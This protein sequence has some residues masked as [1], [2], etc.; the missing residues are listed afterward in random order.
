MPC[1]PMKAAS[2][3]RVNGM[4]RFP[5][6]CFTGRGR[7]VRYRWPRVIGRPVVT[8][9]DGSIVVT[10]TPY[11]IRIVRPEIECEPVAPSA[12]TTTSGTPA[13][14]T[15]STST[16]ALPEGPF[17]TWW[18]ASADASVIV[19]A[20]NEGAFVWDAQHGFRLVADVLREQG[21]VLDRWTLTAATGV[22]ADG[23]VL[24]GYGTNPAGHPEAWR[25]DL[26]PVVLPSVGSGEQLRPMGQVGIRS[27]FDFVQR[28]GGPV[29]A[30]DLVV[31][32]GGNVAG[33]RRQSVCL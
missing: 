24:V 25:A 5:A 30:D 12:P 4:M 19:G 21:Y 22:S 27:G 14:C 20:G 3:E 17:H 13:D 1:H 29:A 8:S 31:A 32:S 15:V 7:R 26:S 6:K 10:N 33:L 28:G 2:M 18:D 11:D 16:T 23:T 9:A